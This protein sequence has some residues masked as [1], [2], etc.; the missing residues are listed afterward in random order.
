M[1][2]LVFDVFDVFPILKAKAGVGMAEIV[3]P[4]GGT[5]RG[6]EE[7]GGGIDGPGRHSNRSAASK[8]SYHLY[9]TPFLSGMQ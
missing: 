6:L 7:G 3:K 4:D 9:I 2:K 5:A 1:A 8:S